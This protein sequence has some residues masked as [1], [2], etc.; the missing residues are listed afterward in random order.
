MPRFLPSPLHASLI[1]THGLHRLVQGT[2][3]DVGRFVLL[4][5]SAYPGLKKPDRN[6]KPHV[7]WSLKITSLGR[8]GAQLWLGEKGQSPTG[9]ALAA[10]KEMV[11]LSA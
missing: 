10:V 7:G 8:G 3:A 2:K 4:P 9:F 6:S 5:T 11:L 1:S